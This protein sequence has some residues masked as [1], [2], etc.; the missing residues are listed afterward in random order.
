MQMALMSI[1]FREAPLFIVKQYTLTDFGVSIDNNQILALTK[2]VKTKA[3]TLYKGVVRIYIY[4]K[5]RQL[6]DTEW[7]RVNRCINL[8]LF[9]A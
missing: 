6:P 8:D 3:N 9:Q 4:T 5:I 1:L 2:A 7:V